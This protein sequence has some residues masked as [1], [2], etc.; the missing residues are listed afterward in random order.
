MQSQKSL[1]NATNSIVKLMKVHDHTSQWSLVDVKK[2]VSTRA[3]ASFVNSRVV[4]ND[5]KNFSR[6]STISQFRVN[7]AKG[8]LKTANDMYVES[9]LVPSK[10]ESN[11]LNQQSKLFY[12]KSTSAGMG[13]GS[14][15]VTGLLRPQTCTAGS[16]PIKSQPMYTN[17]NAVLRTNPESYYP[18]QVASIN[19]ASTDYN[20]I[21]F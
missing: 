1:A 12:L 11:Y 4:T 13:G 10:I 3:S 9:N 5:P 6:P 20:F 2:N 7:G 21:N 14:A 15:S 17:L 19:F 18:G 8:S 16:Q